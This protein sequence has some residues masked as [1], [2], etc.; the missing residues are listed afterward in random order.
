MTLRGMFGGDV[1]RIQEQ[2]DDLLDNEDG[3]VVLF[4][5]S[6]MVSYSH[7][8]GV[9]PCQLELLTAEIE[10]AVKN[11]IGGQTSNEQEEKEEP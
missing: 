2:I 8:F 9:S 10:R 6:R 4:D 5:G 11:V 7:G 3:L 1:R